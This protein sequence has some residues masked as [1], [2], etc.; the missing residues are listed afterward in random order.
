ME[1]LNFFCVCRL[2]P[3]LEAIFRP[4]PQGCGEEYTPLITNLARHRLLKLLS[5]STPPMGHHHPPPSDYL[6]PTP[7]LLEYGSAATCVANPST[8][9]QWERL[10][11]RLITKRLDLPNTLKHD[12]L[13]RY[14]D[15]S[16]IHD[17]LLYL[18]KRC[19][20]ARLYTQPRPILCRK[21]TTNTRR[22][23][24]TMINL[25]FSSGTLAATLTNYEIK[26]VKNKIK[27]K[28]GMETTKTIPPPQK[29]INKV[30]QLKIKHLK[31]PKRIN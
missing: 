25:L 12:I 11:M 28:K 26:K 20:A 7:T 14:A 21:T 16:T 5:L 18:A 29:K 31:K 15:Q 27:N 19:S 24:E 23:T 10:Q 17:R 1:W 22:N 9:V 2:L 30:N 4:A 13:R 3:R 6:T 8:F